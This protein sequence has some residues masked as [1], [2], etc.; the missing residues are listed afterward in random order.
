MTLD[1]EA[2]ALKFAGEVQDLLDDVLP[3]PGVLPED[4]QIQV[5]LS[6]KGK[7]YEVR[8]NAEGGRVALFKNSKPIAYLRV[9]FHCAADTPE[10]YLAVER[11]DFEFGDV[12]SRT[13]IARVDFMRRAHTV[14][15]CHWNIHAERGTASRLLALGNPGHPAEFSKLHFPVG[16]PRMRPCLEDFLQFVIHEFKVD[17]RSGAREAIAAGRE[18]WRR[19]QIATLVRDAPDAAAEA[20]ESFG[21]TVT[22]PADGPKPP[23]TAKLRAW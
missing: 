17:R 20:L 19:R 23:N 14:P 13:P 16:G 8:P 2:E 9:S 5:D 3:A 12:K 21:Y 22:P 10:E 6:A 7:R 15:A 18:R 4:R 1:V 11:S